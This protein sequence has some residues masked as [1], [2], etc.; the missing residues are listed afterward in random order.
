MAGMDKSRLS[1]FELIV[2]MAAGK[3]VWTAYGLADPLVQRPLTS[4]TAMGLI[5]ILGY[6][7]LTISKQAGIPD[8]WSSSVSN[9]RRFLL[10]AGFGLGFG[11]LQIGLV[12]LQ[13]IQVPMV[14]FPLS[15]PVYLSVGILSEL[16][17]H[18]IPLAGILYSITLIR[19]GE[20][21]GKTA[22]WTVLVLLSL[23]EPVLQVYMMLQMDL[24]HAP[25]AAALPFLLIWAA[26]LLPLYFLKRYGLLAA[27]SWR[28]ADYLV[29][30]ILWGMI[31]PAVFASL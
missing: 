24:L 14:P 4:W 20:K 19:G 25:A 9:M 23:W 27:V 12:L 30:H 11:A 7:S 18:F 29:W 6:L 21:P 28:F 2:I 3:I 17:L 31:G 5:A 16:V 26:N 15:I 10:P 1:Y 8:L 13:R 22:V